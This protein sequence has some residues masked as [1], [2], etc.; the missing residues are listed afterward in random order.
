MKKLFLL[1]IIH[2]IPAMAKADGSGICGDS[3]TYYYEESSQTLTISGKGPMEDFYTTYHYV[4][5]TVPWDNTKISRIVI[6][7]NVTYIGIGAFAGCSSLK[8]VEI[9]SSISSIG[10]NAFYGCYALESVFISD[11]KA[12]CEINFTETSSPLY[13]A[14]HLYLNGEEI[15]N[16]KI[17]EGTTQISSY[18]FYGCNNIVSVTI[19]K[20]ITTIGG[21]AF[22]NCE[23]L[24]SIAIP[25]GVTAIGDYAFYGCKSLKSVLLPNSLLHI[26]NSAFRDCSSLV[27]I[28]L[29]DNVYSI[30][31]ATFEGCTSLSSIVIPDSIKT[32]KAAIFSGCSNLSN[33]ILPKN[34]LDIEQYVFSGCKKLKYVA[35]PDS[36]KSIG[37]GAFSFCEMLDSISLPPSLITIQEYTFNSCSRLRSIFIPKNVSVI[38]KWAF[39]NCSHLQAIHISDIAAWCNI[40]MEEQY[41]NPLF[42]AKHIYL[43]GNE[44]VDLVIPDGVKTINEGAFYG[45]YNIKTLSLPNTLKYIK[46]QAFYG[47]SSM[48]KLTLPSSIEV[49]YQEAFAICSSLQQIIVQSDV[50]PFLYDNS[51]SKFD[52]PVIVPGGSVNEYK[53]AS[54][55]KNFDS[56]SG[57]GTYKLTYILDGK[58]YRTF[59]MKDGTVIVPEPS[60]YKEGHTF[61]G[62]SDVPETM[63]ANNVTITGAFTINKYTLTYNVDGEKYKDFEVEFGTAI[64]AVEEPKKE[65]YTFS[66]WS[67]IPETMP[68]NDVTITGT[69]TVNTYTL[70]YMVDGEAYKTYEIDYGTA[71][72]PE[73]EPTKVGHN[74]SGWNDI[75]ETMPA[76]DVTITGTFTI[77]KYKLTYSVDGQEYKDFE[78]E[79]GT[80]ITAIEEPTKEGFTFSGWSEVPKTMPA[81]DVTVTGVFVINTY[82]VTY[83]IDDMVFKTDSVQYGANIVVPEATEMEGYT[84]DGWADVPE[85]MPAHDV[86]INGTYTSGIADAAID[87]KDVR[88]YDIKGRRIPKL[89]RGVN[90]IRTR[91]GRMRKVMMM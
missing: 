85:K 83:M 19:P 18:A 37:F 47:L 25:E 23:S 54:G 72:T 27:Q 5:R 44:I 58:V 61:S 91:D 1:L 69:F 68:A 12:W 15:F 21:R 31:D 40:K 60:L 57:D 35:I 46:K 11:I 63:P 77:N 41:S 8:Y 74:F 66:G 86:T 88:I 45:C 28:N 26:Y 6:E 3:L 43:D 2:I 75:P 17:P 62:W 65:G 53:N 67:E 36:V 90:L 76:N 81:N 39:R 82:Q 20:G 52:V 64:T 9:P 51:F 32:L 59:R 71:I 84:F 29:P 7:E 79:Y 56:I 34:L 80:A 22:Q 50:P 4:G 49:V 10:F 55:W 73:E 16:L 38:E 87:D 24:V 70:T 14:Q 48:E 78:V 89:Q 42:H 30:E 33:I 13:Y